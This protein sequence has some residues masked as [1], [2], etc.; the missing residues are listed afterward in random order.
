MTVPR[1]ML[2]VAAFALLIA[3]T[4]TQC[5]LAVFVGV[6]LFG[7]VLATALSLLVG[8]VAGGLRSLFRDLG[9]PPI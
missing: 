3:P 7:L 5:S 1:M 8:A 6:A 4:T 9:G 2:G